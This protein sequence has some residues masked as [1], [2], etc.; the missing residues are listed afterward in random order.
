MADPEV[1]APCALLSL[2]PVG[3]DLALNVQLFPYG[4]FRAAPEAKTQIPELVVALA[5]VYFC[6]IKTDAP[7]GKRSPAS[8]GKTP[9]AENLEG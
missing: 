5:L 3:S 7:L 4:D 9:S 6:L 2:G 1:F 8:P